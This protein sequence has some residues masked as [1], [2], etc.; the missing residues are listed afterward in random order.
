MVPNKP[1]AMN[2]DHEAL[3]EFIKHVNGRI[4]RL[5]VTMLAG[6][7]VLVVTLVVGILNLV[8]RGG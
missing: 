5:Y 7:G 3:W 2:G 1:K 4:D 6:L 8:T